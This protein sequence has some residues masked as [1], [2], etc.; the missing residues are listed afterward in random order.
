MMELKSCRVLVTPTSYGKSDIRL[1]T[2]L[3][4][5]VGEVVYNPTRRPLTSVELV[6]LLPGCDGY[7]AGLDAVDANA[8]AAADRLQVIARYGVGVDNV[9]LEAARQKGIVVTVTPGANAVSVAELVVGLLLALA[10]QLPSAAAATRSGAWPR[11]SGLTLEGKTIGLL[12]LGATGKQVARRLRGFDCR[13][14]A[15][16]P[17]ADVEWAGRYEVELLGL[18]AVLA[19]ADFLSLHLPLNPQTRHMV[20]REFIGR[21]KPGAYLVNTARGELI[22][23]SALL[24]GLESGQ[25]G[26]AALD[27]FS[28]EPPDATHPLLTHPKV[29][30]TPHC[31]SHTDGATNAMGWAAMRDC[32]AVLNGETPAH[33]VA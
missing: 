18:E 24:N 16:D 5:A 11:L 6:G 32:L 1:F 26:G 15:H 14:L 10:R 9:D 29:I 25:L 22:D 27:V 17:F 33:R 30:V 2:E 8:L 13:I 20:S 12:G 23:D 19:E 28:K 3:E 31:A 7:I 4:N 21:M